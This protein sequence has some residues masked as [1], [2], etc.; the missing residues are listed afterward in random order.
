MAASGAEIAFLCLD[1]NL[2]AD[3]AERGYAAKMRAV[4][5]RSVDPR[6]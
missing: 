5:A 3:E 2:H 4:R 1:C 6:A